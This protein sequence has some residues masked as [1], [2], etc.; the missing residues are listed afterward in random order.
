MQ[1]H[2][3]CALAMANILW[4]TPE[5]M[6]G[7]SGARMDVSYKDKYDKYRL[8]KYELSNV[9]ISPDNREFTVLILRAGGGISCSITVRRKTT[10]QGTGVEMRHSENH[11]SGLREE[12]TLYK[13]KI[14]GGM[15]YNSMKYRCFAGEGNHP[16]RKAMNLSCEIK[17][18]DGK[19]FTAKYELTVT[20]L[21]HKV[22]I[23]NYKHSDKR[24]QK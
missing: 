21:V 19:F 6:S 5:D 17:K 24:K 14:G 10:E 13:N 16:D 18:D 23:S 9:R 20:A 8:N 15:H 4:N 12:F 3:M 1:P 2:S 22:K 11:I 7:V